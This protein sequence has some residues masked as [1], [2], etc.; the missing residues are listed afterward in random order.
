MDVGVLMAHCKRPFVS[1]RGGN[2]RGEQD[3]TDES[4]GQHGDTEK[5]EEW[6]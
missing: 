6:D 2:H 1:A 4:K 5:G 3:V